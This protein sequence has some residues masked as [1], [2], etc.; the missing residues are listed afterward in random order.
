[1]ASQNNQKP[2][3]ARSNKISSLTLKET[4]ID[5][6]LNTCDIELVIV[7]RDLLILE[8]N[9]WMITHSEIA[10]DNA[11]RENFNSV[12]PIDEESELSKAIGISLT[13]QVSSRGRF[14]IH[15]IFITDFTQVYGFEI[16]FEFL[17]LME[18]FQR[19]TKTIRNCSDCLGVLKNANGILV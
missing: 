8:W 17:E 19:T 3:I 18:Y 6:I 11:I 5:A 15:V 12:F 16:A 7:K 14:R 4:T 13:D 10:Q 1:M 2:K 9:N